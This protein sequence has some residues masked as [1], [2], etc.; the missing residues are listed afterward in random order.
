MVRNYDRLNR[1][2]HICSRGPYR[3]KRE[4]V[5]DLVRWD[6]RDYIDQAV[7][8]VDDDD[9][10]LDEDEG[11]ERETIPNGW[12]EIDAR[13]PKYSVF[14]ME[15]EVKPGYRQTLK[16]YRGS[17]LPN[18][19]LCQRNH[20][21]YWQCPDCDRR[22]RH[23]Y[24]LAKSSAIICRKCWN[25]VYRSQS[26]SAAQR[27][28]DY[29]QKNKHLYRGRYRDEC[30]G[31]YESCGAGFRCTIPP[32]PPA[33]WV[34]ADLLKRFHAEQTRHDQTEMPTETEAEL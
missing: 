29:W 3:R 13:D 10:W 18:T 22:R 21:W 12:A 2:P 32:T 19:P 25:V 6:C 27:Q 31:W 33:D 17:R 9:W 23:L 7:P 4:H 16:L 15:V 8:D 20:W 11:E 14:R 26:K 30:G 34:P 1:P 5:E 24:S 28:K